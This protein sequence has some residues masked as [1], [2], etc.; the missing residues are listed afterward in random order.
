MFCWRRDGATLFSYIPKLGHF[1]FFL[2]GGG[3]VGWGS[4]FFGGGGGGFRK[5]EFCL[6]GGV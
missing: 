2:G 5:N 4:F 1:F 6:R 3:G